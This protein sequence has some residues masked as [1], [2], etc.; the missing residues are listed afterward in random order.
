MTI[1]SEQDESATNLK[2]L[3]ERLLT[4]KCQ[5]LGRV[6]MH[7][8]QE[9]IVHH[10][11]DLMRLGSLHPNGIHPSKHIG[12]LAFWI[13]KLKPVSNA[14]PLSVVSEYEDGII[15]DGK[16]VLAINEIL[17]IYVAKHLTIS[18][19]EDGHIEPTLTTNLRQ[20]FIKNIVNLMTDVLS[21]RIDAGHMQGSVFRAF[22]YD[23]RY[24]TFGPHHVVHFINHV[25]YAARGSLRA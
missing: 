7:T 5:C 17:S 15:P 1:S 9:V 16:E 24:R 4:E 6:S 19:I 25:L 3:L 12:Y 21:A 23:A 20:Q 10:E 8:C 14:Y 18:Y 11:R 13:R 2:T 22:I